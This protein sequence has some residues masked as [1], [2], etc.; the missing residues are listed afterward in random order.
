MQKEFNPKYTKL[1][2]FIFTQGIGMPPLLLTPSNRISPFQE[3][4]NKQEDM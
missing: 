2:L 1:P 3:Y 4:N